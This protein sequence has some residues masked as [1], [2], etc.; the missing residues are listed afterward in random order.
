MRAWQ[1]KILSKYYTN[2]NNNDNNFIIKELNNNLAKH[3]KCDIGNR[4]NKCYILIVA[5]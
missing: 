4:Y 5:V 3:D 1:K 2:F